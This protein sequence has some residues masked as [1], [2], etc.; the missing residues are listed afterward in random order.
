MDV[1]C[2]IPVGGTAPKPC[3]CCCCA[4]ILTDLVDSDLAP[5]SRLELSRALTGSPV[6]K[7]E[8]HSI[9]LTASKMAGADGD[10]SLYP[11][12]VLI[13]ELRNEDVQVTTLLNDLGYKSVEHWTLSVVWLVRFVMSELV[14]ANVSRRRGPM[15]RSFSST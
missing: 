3:C 15:W 6:V 1:A 5:N 11:I 4:A 14:H 8:R 13:D 10:D 7:Q 2:C 9:Q 12:A